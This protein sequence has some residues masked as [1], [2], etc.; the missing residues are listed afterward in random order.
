MV[1]MSGKWKTDISKEGT[2]RG[3]KLD[4]LINNL[5][6]TEM[7]FLILKGELPKKNEV[8][9]MDAIFVSCVEHSIA[10]PSITAA[11]ISAS[12][13]NPLNAAV[14]AGILGIGDFHGGAIE[15][16]AKMMQEN[17]GKDA[18]QIV[19]E[20]RGQKKI[21]A[22]FGHKFYKD[23]DPRT[24][25][26]FKIAEENGIAGK[27]VKFAKELEK[28]IEKN[29]GKK[30]VMNVDGSIA[31]ILSDMGF[32]WRLGKGFFVI[33]RVVGITAHVYEEMTKEK[34]FRRLS[35]EDVEYSGKEEKDLPKEFRRK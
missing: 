16:S 20:Y 25:Q 24:I 8:K 11:R 32:D 2:V 12:A 13:G 5:T 31:A 30:L 22:G 33:P 35:E 19:K 10:P 7:I 26:L 4:E 3:Y 21:L 27:H 1:I 6:F 18:D 34:P 9:M 23:S 15:A 28:A 29:L 14:A 17:S